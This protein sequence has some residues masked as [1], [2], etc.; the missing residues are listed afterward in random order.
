[1]VS[2]E[3]DTAKQNMSEEQKQEAA[4]KLDVFISYSTKNKNVADAVVAHFEQN[5]I[6][7]W[8][9]PRDIMPGQEWVSAIKEALKHAKIFVLIYTSESNLSRQVMNEVALAFN[10]GMTIVPFRLTEE[11][12]NDELEYYLTRVHWLDAVSEPLERSISSL[13]DYVKMILQ[14]PKTEDAAKKRDGEGKKADAGR[15]LV[16]EK[17][18]DKA[19]K[20]KGKLGLVAGIAAAVL[21]LI[22][23]GVFAAGQVSKARTNQLMEEGYQALFYGLSGTEDYAKAQE[24]YEEAAQKGV[25]DAHYYLGQI[26][27]QYYDYHAAMEEYE[28]GVSKGSDLARL[29]MGHLWQMGLCGEANAKKA[30]DLY[31][32][33][34]D[35]GCAEADLYLAEI[36]RGGLAG[37]EAD[38]KKALKLLK[39]V[40]EESKLPNMVADAYNQIGILYFNGMMNVPKDREAAL[41]A[42]DKVADTLNAKKFQRKRLYNSGMVYSDMGE[43]V[44]AEDCY[45]AAFQLYVEMAEAGSVSSMYQ[46]GKC[47]RFGNGVEKNYQEAMRW[48]TTADDAVKRRNPKTRCYDALVAIGDLYADGLG[49]EHDYEK[50]YEYYKEASDFG[51][52]TAANR[53]GN[54]YYNGNKGKDENGNPDYKLARQWYEKGIEHGSTDAYCAIGLLYAEGK[55]TEADEAK[56]LEYYM[57]GT[58]LGSAMCATTAASMYWKTDRKEEAF[59]W[60]QVAAG[61]GYVKAYWILGVMYEGGIG[62]DS[63]EEKAIEWYTKAAK[64]E[65]TTAMRFLTESYYEGTWTVGVRYEDAFYWA[66]KGADLKEPYCMYMLG[67][68]YGHGQGTD[69]NPAE[70]AKWYLELAQMDPPEEEEEAAEYRLDAMYQYGK[71]MLNG[72]DGV[73]ADEE[74]GLKWLKKAS[75]EG[76]KD[77]AQYLWDYCWANNMPKDAFRALHEAYSN[78]ID[79]DGE[80]LYCI[81]YC[82]HEGRGIGRNHARAFQFTQLSAEKGDYAI[83]MLYL[84]DMYLNGDGTSVNYGKALQWYGAALDTEMLDEKTQKYCQD[85]IRYMVNQD[86]VSEQDAKKWLK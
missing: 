24:C 47:Y 32:E 15:K 3:N 66:Q 16:K 44:K 35:N 74:E 1:M 31:N 17:Q 49:V 57:K 86:F 45:R 43:A 63:N 71:L 79:L 60:V 46:C 85:T 67:W 73:L 51:F 65:S 12:M 4:N 34:A 77:S 84:A 56:A 23:G 52:G 50:A 41:E 33:A 69:Q 25:A 8:Y 54:L 6:K 68:M 75:A 19:E 42:F 39:N 81:A 38:A 20:K 70:A 21:L 59:Y 27:E 64:E 26:F 72:A 80:Y 18:K 55:G 9:A 10:A 48:F 22:A 53:I 76:N 82:Y 58:E 36:I 7:C 30:W 28:K 37:Q 78:G 29:G 40:T 61:M 83:G 11:M 13:G 5:G 62:V 14:H 2:E